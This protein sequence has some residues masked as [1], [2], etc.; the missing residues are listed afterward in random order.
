MLSTITHHSL[1]ANV[2]EEALQYFDPKVGS[3]Q[4]IHFIGTAT[5]RTL[6]AGLTLRPF[7]YC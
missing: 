1:R 6:L 7:R 5:S 2:K 3:S 4:D